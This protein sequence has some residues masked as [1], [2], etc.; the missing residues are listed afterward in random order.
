MAFQAS[1]AE[2]VATAVRTAIADADTSLT[3]IASASGVPQATLT[4][5]LT[6]DAP[7]NV[8]EL[9]FIARA[10]GI[11]VETFTAPQQAAAA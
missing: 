10:L 5:K 6:T 4:R 3:S 8:R 2:R 11:P 7:F 9:D 1:Y